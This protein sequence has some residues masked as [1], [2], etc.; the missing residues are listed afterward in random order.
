MAASRVFLLYGAYLVLTRWAS[1]L[2]G[3]YLQTAVLKIVSGIRAD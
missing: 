2:T 1:S 3:L